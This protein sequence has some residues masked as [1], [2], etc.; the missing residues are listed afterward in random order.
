MIFKE[1]PD[2]RCEAYFCNYL[3]ILY[4]NS[5]SEAASAGSIINNGSKT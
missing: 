3:K 5:S 2:K 4:K 1:P